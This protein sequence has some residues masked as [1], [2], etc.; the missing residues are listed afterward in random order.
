MK[1]LSPTQ[2]YQADAITLQRQ[3]ISSTEL[4]ERAGTKLF[5]WLDCYLKNSENTI[6]IFCGIGN[7]GGDGLVLGRLLVENG[8]DVRLYVVNYSDNHSKE[9]SDNLKR[10]EKLNEAQLQILKDSKNFP[11]INTEDIIV[12]AIFGIGL[13]RDPKDWMKDLIQHLNKS[14]AYKIAIDIP[15]GLFANAAVADSDSILKA[16]HT[17][18]LQ[19]PKLAFYLPKTGNYV[20][21][22]DVLDI[23]LDSDFLDTVEPLAHLITAKEAV[24][25]YRP[26]EKFGYKN[27]YGHALI[28]GGSYGKIGSTV[29]STKAAFRIG[30]GL[31]TTFIPKSGYSTLQSTIPEAMVLTD[32]KEDFITNIS[33]D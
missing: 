16:N 6:H 15:S 26:R 32:N 5:E 31:V 22:F 20:G 1:I 27:T 30:A 29:L 21:T 9:F 33:V 4:M 14:K 13:N 8:Y 12:D 10:Y 24:K 23:G 11:L 17:L 19:T 2:I 28:V 25:I 18:T 3:N 7:N